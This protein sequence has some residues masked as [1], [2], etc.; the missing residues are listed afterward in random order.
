MKG[1]YLTNAVSGFLSFLNLQKRFSPLTVL[2]YESDLKQF[3]LFLDDEIPRSQLGDITYQDIRSFIASLMDQGIAASSVNRKLSALKSFFR[4][5]VSKEIVTSDPANRIPGPK[6]PKRL[7]VF[8]DENQMRHIFS[9]LSFGNDFEGVRNKLIIDILYQT[10]IRRAE[11]INLKESDVDIYNL[12]LKVLG[13][14]NKERVIP[15]DIALKRNLESYLH[16]KNEGQLSNPC[17]L[18]TVKNKPLSAGLVTKIVSAV[19]GQVTTNKKKSPHVLRHTFATHLLDSGADI[20][21]V[22]E[23]LGHSSLSA[24]QIY[25][26][27]TIDKLKK[28]YNQAHPRS[29]N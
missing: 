26:H 11:L 10:G 23:L 28:S 21:A 14:G 3:F 27:N 25:T 13:K 16:V 18:V 19:L 7:P 15:F 20:N 9:K 17:L 2:N 12:Q 6:I 8:A 24:T 1:H 22:K 4:Y 29:G 5:L